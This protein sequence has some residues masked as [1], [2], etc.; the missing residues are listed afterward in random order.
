MLCRKKRKRERKRER[1]REGK[2]LFRR[3]K[4]KRYVGE[5]NQRKTQIIRDDRVM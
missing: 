5:G 3:M 4:V 1:G 2:V